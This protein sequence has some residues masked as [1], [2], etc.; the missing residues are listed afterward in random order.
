MKIYIE[1]ENETLNCYV[2]G[3]VTEDLQAIPFVNPESLLSS[4]IIICCGEC[5]KTKLAEHFKVFH[6]AGAIQDIIDGRG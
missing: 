2:C 3:Q 5:V 4:Q 6:S 1:V